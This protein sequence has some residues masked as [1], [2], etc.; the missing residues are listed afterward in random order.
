MEGVLEVQ[1]EKGA[2]ESGRARVSPCYLGEN[3][4][5]AEDKA[6]K[7]STAELR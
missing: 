7:A 5:L 3:I 6:G 4:F 2:T 1:S